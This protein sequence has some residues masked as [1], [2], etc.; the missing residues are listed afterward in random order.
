MAEQERKKTPKIVLPLAHQHPTNTLTPAGK[1]LPL[2]SFGEGQTVKLEC[3][4]FLGDVTI[5]LQSPSETIVLESQGV[6]E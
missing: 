1:D 3:P 4:Q 6:I 5:F 2:Y